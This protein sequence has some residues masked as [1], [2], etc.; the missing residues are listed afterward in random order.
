MPSFL[1][2]K[3]CP[4]KKY[5]K[6][7]KLTKIPNPIQLKRKKRTKK[8]KINHEMQAFVQLH[9]VGKKKGSVYNTKTVQLDCNVCIL[10]KYLCTIFS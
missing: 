3:P 2:L 6:Y 5:K 9:I 4:I 8:K 7:K 1:K 10:S